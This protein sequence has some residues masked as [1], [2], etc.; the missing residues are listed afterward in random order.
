[1]AEPADVATPTVEPTKKPGPAKVKIPNNVSKAT[2]ITPKTPATAPVMKMVSPVVRYEPKA[3]P[4]RAAPAPQILPVVP[5]SPAVPP[6]APQSIPDSKHQNNLEVPEDGEGEADDMT[7][8]FE[9]RMVPVARW[10][11]ASTILSLS[12]PI[13]VAQNN[14]APMNNLGDSAIGDFS[15]DANAAATPTEVSTNSVDSG[16]EPVA[17]EAVGQ[18]QAAPQPNYTGKSIKLD[19]RGA[20]LADVIRALSNESGRNFVFPPEVGKQPVN[21]SLASVPWDQALRALLE[22]HALGMVEVGENLI[23]IDR[24]TTLAQEKE[25]REAVRRSAAKL[26]PTKAVIFPLSYAK[27]T[28]L[29][30]LVTSLLEGSREIDR[31]VRVEADERTNS[32]VV[33]A[34]PVDLAKV[35]ALVEKLDMQTPQVQI[36]ARIIEVLKKNDAFAGVNWGNQFN[37]DAGR[38]LGM[39]ALSFPAGIGSQFSVDPGVA[40]ESRT[41]NLNIKFGS[42]NDMLSLDLLLKMEESRQNIEVVQN[43]RLIVQDNEKA[44]LVAG[45]SDYFRSSSGSNIIVGAGGA[46]TGSGQTTSLDQVQYNLSLFAEPHITADG[47]VQM[48]LDIISDSPVAPSSTVQGALAGKTSRELHTTLLRRSGETVVIGGLYTTDRQNTVTG[49]PILSSIPIIGALFRSKQNKDEQRELVIMVTPVILNPLQN[50]T[51]GTAALPP[52]DM[53]P[54]MSQNSYGN[55]GFENSQENA[56]QNN[57]QNSQSQNAAQGQNNSQN[58]NA[59]QVNDEELND[60]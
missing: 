20:P 40:G 43:N 47:S 11:I 3:E 44:S 22:T 56:Q 5:A 49:V 26:T 9:V 10:L 42:I 19:F 16:F 21:I 27:A 48:K 1:M 32:L 50:P 17:G 4:R 23:R 51:G 41:G 24:L 31:R 12:P 25:S 29:K 46:S 52:V 36:S 54:M 6:Q 55:N 14:V 37:L 57:G 18:D 13:L 8:K 28:A 60:E 38:G 30:P 33:E 45:R 59:L 39:G 53:G 15:T 34:I 58:A 7:E 35:K 2:T